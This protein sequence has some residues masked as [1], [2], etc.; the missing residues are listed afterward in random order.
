MPTFQKGHK[1]K[2]ID[3]SFLIDDRNNL[4]T[5][6]YVYTIL[7]GQRIDGEPIKL[8]EFPDIWF[9][10][11]RFQL[12]T[13][14]NYMNTKLEVKLH[15]YGTLLFGTITKQDFGFVPRG[16]FKFIASNGYVIESVSEPQLKPK[17]LY[18][19]GSTVGHD[20]VTMAFN[21]GSAGDAIEARQHFLAA[22]EELNNRACTTM[23]GVYE[24][25]EPEVK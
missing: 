1:V 5:L 22:I 10:C 7:V 21:F 19:L 17:V 8:V 14:E 11:S 9:S 20:N 2:C 12:I 6:G 3:A 13:K 15:V 18:V 25:K 24:A 23:H 4:L 16:K